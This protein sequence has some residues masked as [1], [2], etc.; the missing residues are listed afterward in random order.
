MNSGFV[1]RQAESFAKRLSQAASNEARIRHAYAHPLSEGALAR[2]AEAGTHISRGNW[3]IAG[4]NTAVLREYAHIL[5][6][7]NELAFMN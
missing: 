3:R 7:T 5:L 4:A 6:S 1:R 2:R